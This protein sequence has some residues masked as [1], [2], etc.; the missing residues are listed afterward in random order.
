MESKA[1]EGPAISAK[2]EKTKKALVSFREKTKK[3]V[4]EAPGSI[5]AQLKAAE[6]SAERA[7]A[8]KKILGFE[9]AQRQIETAKK[10]LGVLAALTGKDDER[11]K[12]LSEEYEATARKV[13]E[14]K[15]GL[16]EEIIAATTAPVEA[17][18]GEDKEKLREMILAEWKKLYPADKVLTVRLSVKDWERTVKLQWDEGSKAWEKIDKAFL[19][20]AV[21][22]QTS[23]TVATIYPAYVNRDNM[24]GTMNVGA[25]TKGKGY[26]Q[27]EMLVKNF[28]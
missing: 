5:S 16:R 10:D 25:E 28:K 8:E 19:P 14:H 4:E 18:E 23:E 15:A 6:Q 9:Q 21:I 24:K 27:R 7:K 13:E 26:V 22:V 12:K 20:A 2:F 3:F 11:V 17:Y 1:R